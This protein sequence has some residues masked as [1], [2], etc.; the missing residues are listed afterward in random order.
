MLLLP[1]LLRCR[2][3]QYDGTLMQRKSNTPLRDY[4]PTHFLNIVP[5][6]SLQLSKYAR[7]SRQCRRYWLAR[8]YTL[9]AVSSFRVLKASFRSLLSIQD[10]VATRTHLPPIIAACAILV[11]PQLARDPRAHYNIVR[12]SVMAILAKSHTSWVARLDQQRPLS[13]NKLSLQSTR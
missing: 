2:R 3:C 12:C 7:Q 1:L 9:T 13:V 4:M 10:V 8:L 6:L 5:R 11:R